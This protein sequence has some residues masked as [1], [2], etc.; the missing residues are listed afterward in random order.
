MKCPVLAGRPAREQPAMPRSPLSRLHTR[1][2]FG[3]D[4]TS[5]SV[6]REEV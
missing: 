3:A 1:D 2:D 6:G 4:F 5:R